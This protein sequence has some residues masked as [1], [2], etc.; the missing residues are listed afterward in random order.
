MSAYFI[1]HRRDIRNTERLKEYA[2]GVGRTI[3]RYNGK[4][5]V[6]S[7][8]FRALEGEWHPGERGNDEH[9]ERITVIEFP[10]METLEAWYESDDYAPFRK[11]RTEAAECDAAAVEGR[12]D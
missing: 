7:D 8:S 5:V 10:D 4:V 11:I 9:P 12:R 3:D 6:R 1:V 2:D